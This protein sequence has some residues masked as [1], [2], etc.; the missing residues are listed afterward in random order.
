MKK[1]YK[2]LLLFSCLIIVLILCNTFIIN[3]LSGYKIVLFLTILLLIFNRIFVIEKDRHLYFKDVLFEIF[4]F[5]MAFF[6]LYYLIGLFVGL[7]K[8]ANYLSFYSIRVIILP[9]ILYC[10]LREVFRYNMLCKADGSKKLTVLVI[11]LF[12]FFDITNTL[13]FIRQSSNA[14]LIKFLTLTL[15]PVIASNIA[16]SFVSKKVGYKPLIVFDIVF[17]MYPYIFPIIP[18]PNEYVSSILNLLVPVFFGLRI[19]KFFTLKKDDLIQRDYKKS[20]SLIMIFPIVIIA[21]LIYFYSGYFRFFT[22]AIASG[23]MRPTIEI[24]DIV[25]IDQKYNDLEIN[26]I[27]AFKKENAIIVHRIIDKIKC[28]NEYYYY[29]KGDAN[30]S[31]DNFTVEEDMVLGKVSFIVP[32]IGYPTIWLSKNS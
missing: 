3:F 20:K 2:K 27:I 16:Y 29:T 9:I 17:K 25:I 32:Y 21:T 5:S 19:L 23:S 7:A 8:T 28:G 10:I 15:I 11:I 24:G 6:I 26:D 13:Y 12:I 4:L 31:P 22:L 30:N 18:N 14:D 1:G